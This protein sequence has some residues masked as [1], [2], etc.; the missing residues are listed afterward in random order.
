[1]RAEILARMQQQGIACEVRSVH[2]DELQ[3]LQS[4]FFCNA[5]SAMKMVTQ[6]ADHALDVASCQTLF[7]QLQLNRIA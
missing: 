2:Q 7:A 6:F 1:M 4:L 3:Q 5:L